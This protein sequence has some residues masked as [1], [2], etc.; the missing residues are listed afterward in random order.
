MF[1][2]NN[3]TS[4][5]LLWKEIL[6]K[7]QKVLKYRCWQMLASN[8]TNNNCYKYLNSYV[9]IC[10]INIMEFSM[11][12]SFSSN[13]W[14]KYGKHIFSRTYWWLLLYLSLTNLTA[15]SAKIHRSVF[16]KITIDLLY[17]WDVFDV[18]LLEKKNRRKYSLFMPSRYLY[19]ISLF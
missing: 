13:I 17:F 16:R 1:I 5:H 7:Y 6:V 14:L 19:I 3:H 2:S 15:H 11:V 8:F 12:I 10:Y 9:Q 4:F 18:N